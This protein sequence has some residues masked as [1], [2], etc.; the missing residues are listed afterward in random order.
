MPTVNGLVQRV[1]LLADSALCC[2]Q[3]GP[4]PT[5]TTLLFIQRR[6]T[7][8]AEVGLMKASMVEGVVSAHVGRR[9]VS[10]THPSGSSE[11]TSLGIGP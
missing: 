6:T 8:T 1:T 3:I 4:S 5:N 9:E 2:V 10:A 11:I 7:D